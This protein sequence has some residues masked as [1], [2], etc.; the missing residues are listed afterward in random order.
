MKRKERYW[1]RRRKEKKRSRTEGARQVSFTAMVYPLWKRGG[2]HCRYGYS[3]LPVYCWGIW[4]CWGCWLWGCH[5]PR[6]CG[7]AG[8]REWG[9]AGV[10]A[11]TTALKRPCMPKPRCWWLPGPFI[12]SPFALSRFDPIILPFRS[13]YLPPFFAALFLLFLVFSLLQRQPLGVSLHLFFFSLSLSL[14]FSL[15]LSLS[16][17]LLVSFSWLKREDT[18]RQDKA[19]RRRLTSR[20]AFFFTRDLRTRFWPPSVWKRA[21]PALTP[22]TP[23]IEREPGEIFERYTHTYIHTARRGD[24]W[25]TTRGDF[26]LARAVLSKCRKNI[27]A[28]RHVRVLLLET[29]GTTPPIP[30]APLLLHLSRHVFLF[31]SFLFLSFFFGFS[32]IIFPLLLSTKVKKTSIANFYC[33]VSSILTSCA[34]DWLA[35]RDQTPYT[36]I[37]SSFLNRSRY[38][39]GQNLLRGNKF[40]LFVL[41]CYTSIY[42]EN[43][44]ILGRYIFRRVAREVKRVL[45]PRRKTCDYKRSGRRKKKKKV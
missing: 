22:P 10:P 20:L 39:T 31:F 11:V 35:D 4:A 8:G 15:S 19:R 23:S 13:L 28:R 2:G 17:C 6:A 37:S 41:Y 32:F 42:W 26:H 9:P 36:T 7:G 33:R 3:L 25:S 45:F 24:R 29:P 21:R 44:A 38:I 40:V 18:T 27:R 1:N 12:F 14:S 30:R 43:I 34:S 5:P 16:L